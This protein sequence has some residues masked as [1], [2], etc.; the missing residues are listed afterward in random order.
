MAIPLIAGT[1]PAIVALKEGETVYWCSCGRSQKQ[2]F[3]DGSHADTE[4]EPLAF[5]A[6]GDD[7][8]YFCTCKRT[9]KPPFCDGAHKRLLEDD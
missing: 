8:Y 4:F 7:D 6:P 1:K 3:C 2:P 5:T 9:K